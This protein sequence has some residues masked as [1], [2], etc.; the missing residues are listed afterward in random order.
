M[1]D[2]LS[3]LFFPVVFAPRRSVGGFTAT[4]TIDEVGTDEL[5]ITD[6]P[7]QSGA[8]VTD[9]AYLKPASLNLRAQW[10]DGEAGMPLDELYSRLR[11]LQS[12][13]VP[14]DVITGRRSYSDMLIK[15]LT[16]T[17]D[18]S[19]NGILAVSFQLQQIIIVQVEAVTIPPRAK[20]KQPGRTGA[21]EKAGQKAP[22]KANDVKKDSAL[23]KIAKAI[24][25]EETSGNQRAALPEVWYG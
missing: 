22:V 23:Q 13:R 25:G 5:V 9:H 14:F 20:Q 19:T 1:A 15:T 11:E 24:K 12:S 2:F 21:T 16:V 4:L 17:T 8:S 10:G 3:N 18:Q 7:V 6:H